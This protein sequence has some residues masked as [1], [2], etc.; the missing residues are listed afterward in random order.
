MNISYKIFGTVYSI[1]FLTQAYQHHQNNFLDG[2]NQ[3][4]PQE[5]F[6]TNNISSLLEILNRH[7]LIIY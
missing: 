6:F 2:D 7:L 1:G 3:K 4:G 5:L